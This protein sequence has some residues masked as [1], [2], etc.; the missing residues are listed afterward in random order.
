MESLLQAQYVIREGSEGGRRRSSIAAVGVVAVGVARIGA[1]GSADDS[2]QFALVQPVEKAA[3]AVIDDDVP[4][5]FVEMGVHGA[6][7]LGAFEA[8][9]ERFGIGRRLHGSRARM[10]GAKLVEE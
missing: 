1:I 2:H 8:A 9:I 5:P 7:A 4:R 6:V 10:R 3:R